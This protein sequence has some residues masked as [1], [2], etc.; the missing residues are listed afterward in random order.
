[1]MRTLD[2]RGVNFAEGSLQAQLPRVDTADLDVSEAAAELIDQVR[3]GGSSALLEQSE[4]FDGTAPRAVRLDPAIARAALGTLAPQLREAIELSIERVRRAS[5]LQVPESR[6]VELAPGASITQRFVPVD[7]AG[8]YVPGGKAV[9]PSSVVMNVVAAQVAGV[10]SIALASPPQ[11]DWE[12][13]IHPTILATAALLDVD[14][15]Y[16]MGG[17][18]AVGALAYGV[19]D[20]GLDAVSVITGPGNRYVAAAKR[21]VKGVVGIDSEA[22]PTEIVVIADSRAP[23]ESVAADLVSQAEHDELAQAILI[24]TDADYA[25]AVAESVSRRAKA[26]SHSD[27]ATTALSGPQSA[28]ILVDSLEQAVLVSDAL[29]PEHLE[30]LTENARDVAVSI[31]H[32]GAIFVGA[33]TPV[34]AGDYLAGSNHVLP[35]GG[36]ASFQSGLSALTFLRPQQIV[37]YSHDALRDISGPLGVFARAEN[38]PAHAEAVE[39]RFVEG[40]EH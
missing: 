25:E 18:G 4:R 38:L 30:I 21:L 23:I 26:T 6:S 40:E 36:R 15:L 24:T 34:S 32:A 17:A 39:A 10:S 37:E 19:G 16:Q 14:E 8:V 22:G 9:Y 29:A 35:T 1:M 12:A 31:R 27:R 2:W 3:R 20:I 28:I 7:R 11:A 13:Q 33:D 5:A